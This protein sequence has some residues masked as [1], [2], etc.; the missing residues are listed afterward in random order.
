MKRTRDAVDGFAL[1]NVG[2]DGIGRSRGESTFAVVVG[3]LDDDAQAVD[4]ADGRDFVF[5]THVVWLTLHGARRICARRG[6][7]LTLCPAKTCRG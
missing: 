1:E 5:D 6:K 4:V 3:K 7:P 2:S